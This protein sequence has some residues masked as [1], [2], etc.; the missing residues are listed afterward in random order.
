MFPI[1]ANFSFKNYV[2]LFYLSIFEILLK[3]HFREILNATNYQLYSLLEYMMAEKKVNISYGK[4]LFIV[5]G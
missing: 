5:Y 1:L 4:A 2:V 3:F